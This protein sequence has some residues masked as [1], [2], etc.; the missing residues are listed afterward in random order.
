MIK[1]ILFDCDGLVIKRDKYFSL[2][3]AETGKNLDMKK[4][5]DFFKNR[6]LFC[7]TGQADLKEELERRIK[8]WGF[9]GSLEE[10]LDFWFSGEADTDKQMLNYIE[11]LR[12]KGSKCYLAT[13][14]EKHRVNYLLDRVVGLGKHFDG[15]FAS[16]DLGYL[17]D[18]KE[19]WEGVSKISGNDNLS[20]VLVWDDDIKNVESAKAFGYNAELYS[21]F[22]GFKNKMKE[23]GFN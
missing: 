22:D 15:C 10:L 18:Q 19:F 6:F 4:I 13:N 16:C 1:I 9:D 5:R 23:Y 14:N 2:R 3:L 11:G 20:E 8:D 12:Q 17:K 7:E 21:D